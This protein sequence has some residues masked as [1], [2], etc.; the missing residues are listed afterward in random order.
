[1]T[2][3]R[4]PAINAPWPVLVII[5]IIVAVY[6]L[7]LALGPDAVVEGYGFRPALLWRG[8]FVGLVTAIF[9]HGGW[10]HLAA[11]AAFI[12]AFGTPVARRMGTDGLG[13]AAFFAF[14]LVCGVIGNLGFAV[15]NSTDQASL[16][17]ASGAAAGLMG[18][19]SRLIAPPP[20]L[21]PFRSRIV[22]SM[23]VAWLVI[24]L[25]VAVVGWAPGSGGAPV[26]WQAHLA[27]YAAG[28]LLIAPALRLL[29]R[30]RQ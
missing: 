4:E 16:I 25:I 13:A 20:L 3:E 23:A 7:Q 6:G 1:M 12:L 9:L 22:I 27:G 17:G 5:G 24:N 15:V 30:A 11:N 26:A 21:A 29:S 2:P 19:A 10:A 8:E 28:V 14:F 18:A